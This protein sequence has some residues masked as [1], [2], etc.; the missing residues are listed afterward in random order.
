MLVDCNLQRYS[1]SFSRSST[2]DGDG[3]DDANDDDNDIDD[4]DVDYMDDHT[5]DHDADVNHHPLIIHTL[6]CIRMIS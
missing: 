1:S 6:L 5:D 4:S 3:V 2:D